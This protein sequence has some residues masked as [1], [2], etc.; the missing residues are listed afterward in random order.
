MEELPRPSVPPAFDERLRSWIGWFGAGR[1]AGSAIAVV[2]VCAGAYWLVRTP[3]PPTEASLPRAGVPTTLAAGAVVGVTDGSTTI[4]PSD[5][6]SATAAAGSTVEPATVVVHVAGAVVAPGVY[7]LAAGARAGDA[8]DAAGGAI[9]GADPDALN[10][11]APLTDGSRIYV[12][13]TG[14]EVPAALLPSGGSDMGVDESIVGPPA[15][16]DVNRATTDELDAL[17][18]VGPATA[19]AIVTERERNG[20]FVTVDDLERVPGIGPA[21]LEALRDLVTT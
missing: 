20:P 7:D 6:V 15:P 1:I 5:D 2:V 8:I 13:L 9:A 18:G 3:T 4:T 16:V 21:K 19:T 11:A 17:P 14:E 12:P 10:L